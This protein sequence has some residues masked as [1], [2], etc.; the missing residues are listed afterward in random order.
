MDR[1]YS[2][3]PL[4]GRRRALCVGGTEVGVWWNV[5]YEGGGVVGQRNCC[6]QMTAEGQK[7]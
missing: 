1:G 5:R 4:P 6:G 3:G 2:A 7:V